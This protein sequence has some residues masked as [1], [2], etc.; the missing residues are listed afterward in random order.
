MAQ[1]YEVRYVRDRKEEI[2]KVSR[3]GA[4]ALVDYLKTKFGITAE[5][6]PVTNIGGH[7]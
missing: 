3:L 6:H 4:L 2:H 7:R 1:L 5:M